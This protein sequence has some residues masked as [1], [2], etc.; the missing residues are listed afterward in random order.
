[1]ND[2]YANGLF[3]LFQATIEVWEQFSWVLN[4]GAKVQLLSEGA[5]TQISGKLS[6][7]TGNYYSS[8]VF[9]R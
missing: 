1:M 3:V 2:L 8:T 9:E 4:Y 6:N 5:V 7:F